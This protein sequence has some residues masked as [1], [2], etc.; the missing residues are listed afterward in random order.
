M[1]N[2]P[3]EYFIH[4]RG[5]FNHWHFIQ[6]MKNGYVKIWSEDKKKLCFEQ[7][8]INNELEGEQLSYL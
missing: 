2:E 7:Y 5:R 1:N 3:D 6:S 4:S 8:E